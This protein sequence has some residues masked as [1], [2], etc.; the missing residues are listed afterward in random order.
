V[1]NDI[2]SEAGAV[3][4]TLEIFSV[5][6]AHDPPEGGDVGGGNRDEFVVIIPLADVLND[7][8]DD[9][10]RSEVQEAR[11]SLFCR[12]DFTPLRNKLSR[13][14][15]RAGFDITDRHYVGWERSTHYRHYVID[16]AKTYDFDQ[17]EGQEGEI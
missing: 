9:E 13:A 1:T 5:M 17:N 10:P 15:L 2:I 7:Y 11:L 16:I 4:N 12:G 8:S 3:I 6:G 14:L